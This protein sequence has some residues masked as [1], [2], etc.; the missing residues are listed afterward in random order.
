MRR[1]SDDVLTRL[2]AL[3]DGRTDRVFAALLGISRSYWAH[4]RTG[5]RPLSPVVMR[6]AVRAFPVLY[7]FAAQELLS[8][9]SKQQARA[10]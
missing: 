2:R 1:M 4:I 9:P 8:E 6:R 3:Q 7:P 10:S 5:R